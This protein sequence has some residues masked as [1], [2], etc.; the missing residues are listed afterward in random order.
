[1]PTV[2]AARSLIERGV[3]GRLRSIRIRTLIDKPA[4]YWA[5]GPTGAV[6]DPWRASR[7]RAGGGIVLMNA[8]HQLDLVRAITHLEPLRVA[9]LV[10]AGVPGVEVEDVAVATIAWSGDVLGS[11]VALAHGPGAT[12]A[13]TIEI[14][15][16]DGALRLGDLYQPRPDLDWFRRP[17]ADGS[18]PERG[19]WRR[20]RPG[21]IDPFAATI[22]GFVESIQNG[23]RPVPGLGDADVALATV[24]A[25]YR[26]SRSGRFEP[27]RPVGETA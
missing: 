19:A 9:G 26:S 6:R 18:D 21:P 22:A 1:M 2:A 10:E 17:A 25:L 13:E 20:E 4:D 15:G 3:L 27:V 12:A 11:L 24:L 16:D 5:A 8:I 14:D 7:A 23:R